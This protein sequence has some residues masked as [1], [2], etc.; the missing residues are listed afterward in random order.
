MLT[1]SWLKIT[2]VQLD[3]CLKGSLHTHCCQ[4]F[5]ENVTIAAVIPRYF[6]NTKLRSVFNQIKC[7]FSRLKA[8][9]R[10]LNRS[11]DFGIEFL[12]TIIFSCFIL[13]NYWETVEA[14]VNRDATPNECGDATA[15]QSFSSHLEKHRLYSYNSSK[16]RLVRESLKKYFENTS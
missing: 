10:I 16:G 4:D 5:W 12:P 11:I 8:S 2:H 7:A 15:K 1:E 6:F 9:W 14:P 13:H 3:L